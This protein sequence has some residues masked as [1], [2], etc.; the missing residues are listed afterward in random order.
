[1]FLVYFILNFC[2]SFFSFALGEVI[3]LNDPAL[4]SSKIFMGQDRD[5]SLTGE[6]VL[7]ISPIMH[8]NGN[9]IIPDDIESAFSFMDDMLPKWYLKALKESA[10]EYECSVNVNG[11]SYSSLIDS[12]IWIKWL[13]PKESKLRDYFNKKGI[14]QHDIIIDA[15]QFS[16][17]EYLK[18][19]RLDNYNSVIKSYSDS[20]GSPRI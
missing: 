3:I 18:T 5:L 1:M 16:F 4:S 8:T 15:L 20:E 10:G 11:S 9:I 13:E 17:C 12:W 19:G 2:S 6:H 14:Y 7:A